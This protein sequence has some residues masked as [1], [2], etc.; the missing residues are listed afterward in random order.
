MAKAY[1]TPKEE[2]LTF[3]KSIPRN[4]VITYRALSKKFNC[5]PR[6]IQSIMRANK[7]PDRNP[8]HKVVPNDWSLGDYV[9]GE[10]ERIKRLERDGIGIKDGKVEDKFIIYELK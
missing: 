6:I 10:A 2:V 4:K 5:H 7:D 3:L 1:L 9:L 8:S